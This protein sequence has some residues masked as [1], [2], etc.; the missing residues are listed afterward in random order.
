[1]ER[2]ICHTASE[3][4][5]AG[6]YDLWTAMSAQGDSILTLEL[7]HIPMQVEKPFFFGEA[8][9]HICVFEAEGGALACYSW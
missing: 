5:L 6:A 3:V 9:C 8:V 7:G 4:A 1:M 2:T